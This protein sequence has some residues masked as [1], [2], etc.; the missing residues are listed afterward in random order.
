MVDLPKHTGHRVSA[1]RSDRLIAISLHV[2]THLKP[3]LANA[4]M[5]I[6]SS[7]TN[8][9]VMLITSASVP[10]TYPLLACGI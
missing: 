6:S 2:C 9:N 3:R 1:S 4:D 10:V 5:Q 8:I 7:E